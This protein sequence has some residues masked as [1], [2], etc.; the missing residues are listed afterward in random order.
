MTTKIISEAGFITFDLG[1][2]KYLSK[3]AAFDYDHTLVIP[4]KGTF[5]KSIDDFQW[6][7]PNVID[8]IRKLYKDDF[9]I[10]IFTNQSKNFKVEQ[11]KNVLSK[12]EIPIRVYIGVSDEF[13]KPSK[14]MWDL[15]KDKSVEITEKFYCGDALGRTGDWSDSDKVFAEVCDLLIKTPEEMFPFEEKIIDEF[16][17]SENQELV[18]MVGYPAA[19]KTTYVNE[20]IPE[21][22][23]KLHGDELK[24]DSKKKKAVKIALT[25][26][27][28]V[29]LDATNANKDK[30][31]IFIDIAKS[32]NVKVRVIHITTSFD[33][34][35]SRNEQRETKVPI[36]ALYMFRKKFEEITLSE[37]IEEI[38][39]V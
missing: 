1:D 6:I 34:S 23:V 37:G 31:K 24:T 27:K 30:R 10:V 20:K 16:V 38:I 7:R 36:I 17:Q 15:F 28:S 11:I 12:L 39:V 25:E 32:L 8:I 2:F 4:K 19:G 35:K 18:L 9:S 29:V 26:G 13:K 33:E 5:S 22:Y 3:V 21:S 14:K